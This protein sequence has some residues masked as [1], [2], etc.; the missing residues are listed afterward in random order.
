MSF[1]PDTPVPTSLDNICYQPSLQVCFSS[2]ESSR[3][4]P[5][6]VSKSWAEIPSYHLSS[7]NLSPKIRGGQ[8]LFT[9]R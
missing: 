2:T 1:S 6:S 4:E 3:A 7:I 9:S 5:L 8:R